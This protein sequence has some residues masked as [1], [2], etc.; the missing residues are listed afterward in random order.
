MCDFGIHVLIHFIDLVIDEA[1]NLVN[2]TLDC[3][4]CGCLEANL[5]TH[6]KLLLLFHLIDNFFEI[7]DFCILRLICLAR[8]IGDLWTNGRVSFTRVNFF[9]FKR[10]E[11][12]YEKV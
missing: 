5:L 7:L 10:T 3:L 11:Q 1:L 2:P 9:Y 8:R 12:K 6:K 4:D